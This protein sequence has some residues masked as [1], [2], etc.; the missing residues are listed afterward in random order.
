MNAMARLVIVAVLAAGAFYCVWKGFAF[1]PSLQLGAGVLVAV[2]VSVA[3]FMILRHGGHA[4][5]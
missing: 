3:V 1:E 5:P 2:V 4:K